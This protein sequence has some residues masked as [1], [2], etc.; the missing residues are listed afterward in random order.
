MPSTR[1]I[2]A[3]T[4]AALKAGSYTAPSGATVS[5]A[6]SLQ[7]CVQ[8]TR[9]Y[10]PD[11]LPPLRDE[12][13]S[14]PPPY[15]AMSIEVVNETTLEG[16]ARL[17][18]TGDYGRIGALNF[19]SAKN[20]GGGFLGGAKAQEES[21]ARSS[22][23]Y[24]SLLKC[25]G[26]YQHHRKQG[27]L[28]YS[29]W[30]I[31]SPGVPI[32]RTDDGAWLETIHAV[33]FITSPAPNAGAI[34]LTERRSIDQIEPTLIERCSKVLALAA[35]HQCEV[36]VLGAWGCG[37]FKN[38]PHMV[39]NAFWKFLHPGGLYWGRFRRVL[40]SVL[41]KHISQSTISAFMKRFA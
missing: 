39:A 38:D 24:P 14:Q 28:L 37:V 25:T 19:A 32:L 8:G 22:G 13:L 29:D 36:V 11:A 3:E 35:Y 20:P 7:Q 10:K 4:V 27:S 9:C 2:A 16:C 30:M 5:L 18:A 41:D 12:V 34:R 26:Y 1:Q 15:S 6:E 40:F 33:D 17:V 21:I 31:Y 23:L